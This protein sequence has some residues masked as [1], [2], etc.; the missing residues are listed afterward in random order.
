MAVDVHVVFTCVMYGDERFQ[1]CSNS[2]RWVPLLPMCSSSSGSPSL[3]PCQKE[4][5]FQLVRTVTLHCTSMI[6]EVHYYHSLLILCLTSLTIYISKTMNIQFD[7][8]M[9]KVLKHCIYIRQQ[10]VL[11][12]CL[13]YTLFAC[14]LLNVAHYFL[15]KLTNQK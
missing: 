5:P 12:T 9:Q 11:T 4:D 10:Q 7:N 13:Q 2:L 14:S 15:L 1:A 8:L 3:S 6:L